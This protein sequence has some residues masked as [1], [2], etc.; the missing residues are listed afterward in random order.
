MSLQVPLRQKTNGDSHGATKAVILVGFVYGA[1]TRRLQTNFSMCIRLV[2][3]R[4]APVSAL[5]LL[6]S[7]R[8]ALSLRDLDPTDSLEINTLASKSTKCPAQNPKSAAALPTSQYK[9]D[10][11][12]FHIIASLRRRRPP[13]HLPLPDCHLESPLCPR[14]LPDRL[15]RR[16]CVPRLPQGRSPRLP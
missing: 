9:A 4:V 14:S 16:V 8:Y 7:P 12:F 15:L 3:L 5:C 1:L 10:R 13:H 11:V 6:T 2:V